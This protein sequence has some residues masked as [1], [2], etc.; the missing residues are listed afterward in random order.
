MTRDEQDLLLDYLA[1][2]RANRE[3]CRALIPDIE[4]L[5]PDLVAKWLAKARAEDRIK[6]WR[7]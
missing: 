1:P 5:L 2:P 4:R 6:I 7:G 3:D